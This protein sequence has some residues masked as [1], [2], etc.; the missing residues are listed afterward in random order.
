MALRTAL[1]YCFDNLL[2]AFECFVQSIDSDNR[3]EIPVG[4][5]QERGAKIVVSIERGREYVLIYSGE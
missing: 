1:E 2:R 5:V 3:P 4:H